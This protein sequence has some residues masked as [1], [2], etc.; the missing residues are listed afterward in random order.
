M[1]INAI[2]SKVIPSLT[3]RSDDAVAMRI[4]SWLC[5]AQSCNEQLINFPLSDFTYKLFADE[6]E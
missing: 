2:L 1:T 6:T 5:I 3:G 4:F